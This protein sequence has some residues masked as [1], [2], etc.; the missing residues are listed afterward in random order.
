MQLPRD[1]TLS[2]AKGEADAPLLKVAYSGAGPHER[3]RCNPVWLS[4]Y[5]SITGVET[6]VALQNEKRELIQ[7]VASLEQDRDELSQRLAELSVR[8]P[9]PSEREQELLEEIDR[10]AAAVASLEQER[11]DLLTKMASLERELEDVSPE[12]RLSAS[13]LDLENDPLVEVAVGYGGLKASAFEPDQLPRAIDYYMSLVDYAANA[14]FNVGEAAAS[15]KLAIVLREHDPEQADEYQ[16]RANMLVQ[17]LVGFPPNLISIYDDLKL[18][19]QASESLTEAERVHE[20]AVRI[21]QEEEYVWGEGSA[22]FDLGVIAFLAA[23][24]GQAESRFDEA[25]TLFESINDTVGMAM[26]LQ[27]LAVLHDKIKGP[28]AADDYRERSRSLIQRLRR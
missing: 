21:A 16:Q 20:Q 15:G 3:G 28:D 9:A 22:K 1:K 5:V 23:K 4:W 14:G 17:E 10:L 6:I 27:N 12:D 25:L 11:A 19:E 24:Y 26:T 8:P 18:T 2:A 7:D 13:F